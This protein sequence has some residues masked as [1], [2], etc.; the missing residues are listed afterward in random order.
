MPITRNVYKRRDGTNTISLPK[1]WV[2]DI[3]EKCGKKLR[4]VYMEVFDGKIVIT[5]KISSE[6]EQH[7]S[8]GN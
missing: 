3:E 5:P 2:N 8:Q 6:D 7:E 1:S 4:V